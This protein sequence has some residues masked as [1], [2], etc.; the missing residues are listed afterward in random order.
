[1]NEQTVSFAVP[2]QPVAKARPRARTVK[3]KGTLGTSPRDFTSHIYTPQGTSDYEA[4]CRVSVLRAMQGRPLFDGAVDVDLEFHF[5]MPKRWNEPTREQAARG[6]IPH[7]GKPDIDNLAKSLLDALPGI[8][9]QDDANVVR[10]NLYKRY[11][12]EPQTLV[13]IRGW[14]R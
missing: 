12:H 2:G 6:V 1:M 5:P 9:I 13:T 8:A 4:R 7:S 14:H 10:L 11:G 3:R